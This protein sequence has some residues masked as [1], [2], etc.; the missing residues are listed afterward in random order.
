M[1]YIFSKT[2]SQGLDGE[3]LI[4]F[5]MVN[6]FE[7]LLSTFYN[8][9]TKRPTTF[10]FKVCQDHGNVFSFFGFQIMWSHIIK[11]CCPLPIKLCY[12]K[13]TTP[14][15]AFYDKFVFTRLVVYAI[16][17][18]IGHFGFRW[19]HIM[20]DAFKVWH[21]TTFQGCACLNVSDLKL[22][23]DFHNIFAY[24]VKYN[25]G[26]ILEKKLFHFIL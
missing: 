17:N 19:K 11:L 1:G 18:P 2:L 7:I 24:Y 4:A 20:V 16:Y 5:L 23:K 26:K 6:I 25:L 15:M 12:G 21:F 10:V 14:K 3:Y 8:Y 9:L 13:V 22:S